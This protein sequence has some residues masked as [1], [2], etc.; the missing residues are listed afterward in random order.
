MKIYLNCEKNMIHMIG[1]IYVY[2]FLL[3]IEILKNKDF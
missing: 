3:F 2:V 1:Y